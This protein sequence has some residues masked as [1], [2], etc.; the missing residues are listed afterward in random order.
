MIACALNL[1]VNVQDVSINKLWQEIH[2]QVIAGNSTFLWFLCLT[3]NVIA[4][5]TSCVFYLIKY[6]LVICYIQSIPPY[7]KFK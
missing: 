3:T 1:L 2:E 7:E 4:S 5:F 6:H